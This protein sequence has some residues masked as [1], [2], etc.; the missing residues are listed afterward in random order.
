MVDVLVEA[1]QGILL[2]LPGSVRPRRSTLVMAYS[3]VWRWL[4]GVFAVTF[5][6][7]SLLLAW[8]DD[9]SD[10]VIV[11]AL[12]P[13]AIGA[14][15]AGLCYGMN[16]NVV[17][18]TK[19]GV[20]QVFRKRRTWIAW[21]AVESVDV[22]GWHGGYVFTSRARRVSVSSSLGGESEFARLV[23]EHVPRKS[24]QCFDHLQ[25]VSETN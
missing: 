25:G 20:A 8:R 23:L 9:W 10:D 1:A 4:S 7:G 24:I 13:T 18:V 22:S 12:V 11:F 17:L 6:V 5:A 16:G 14:L 21:H 2:T 3:V 19:H 15:F